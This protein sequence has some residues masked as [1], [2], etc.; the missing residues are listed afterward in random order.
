MKRPVVLC[1]DDEINILKSLERCFSTEDIEVLL[2]SSGKE[3][4]VIL[5]QRGQEINLMIIDQRMPEMAGDELL[6]NVRYNFPLLPMIML[7]GYAD[8]EGLVRVISSGDLAYFI[9]KPWSNKELI[10]LV[11]TALRRPFLANGEKGAGQ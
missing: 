10:E 1:V 3:A 2:A 11:H 9:A 4:L 7:S 6:K 8:F 5:Q